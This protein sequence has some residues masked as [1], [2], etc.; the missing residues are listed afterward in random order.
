M[1]EKF[2]FVAFGEQQS[3]YL[4]G[5]TTINGSEQTL[6]VVDAEVQALVNGALNDAI[7]ILRENK[8]KLHELAAYLMKKE[9]ITGDEFMQ[10]LDPEGLD[11]KPA[12]DAEN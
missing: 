10:I 6:K 3:K 8:F 5:G 9:T 4:G 7:Q 2:V 12:E 11:I 1:S